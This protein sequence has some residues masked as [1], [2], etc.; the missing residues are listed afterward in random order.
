MFRLSPEILAK[1][2]KLLGKRKNNAGAENSCS[3]AMQCIPKFAR[4]V[5]QTEQAIIGNI[6]NIEV[7][8]HCI[9]NVLQ[10]I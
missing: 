9:N 1:I 4:K 7:G 10:G 5:W 8:I 2:L 6:G 3:Y